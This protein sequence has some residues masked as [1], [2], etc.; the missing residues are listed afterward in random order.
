MKVWIVSDGILNIGSECTI[1]CV[2][3]SI[4]IAQYIVKA[5]NI[6]GLTITE[7]EVIQ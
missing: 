1:K 4:E 3:G 7:F 6:Y 5:F 2:C